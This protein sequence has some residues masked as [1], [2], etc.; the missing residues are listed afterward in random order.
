MDSSIVTAT[1]QPT[2]GSRTTTVSIAE[3]PVDGR[4]ILLTA[5]FVVASFVIATFVGAILLK[6]AG[7]LIAFLF[8]LAIPPLIALFG[9][10]FMRHQWRDAITASFVVAYLLLLASALGLRAFGSQQA[11]AQTYSGTLL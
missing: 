4:A 11:D 5:S 3:L 9:G 2:P 6:G 8:S 10:F 1:T 7:Q